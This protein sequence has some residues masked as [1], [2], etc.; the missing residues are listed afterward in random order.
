MDMIGHV[1]SR[2]INMQTN[3]TLL[4]QSITNEIDPVLRL[5]TIGRATHSTQ[6]EQ[7]SPKISML[8]SASN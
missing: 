3:A 7:V 8:S 6:T 5:N 1:E 2:I 4:K